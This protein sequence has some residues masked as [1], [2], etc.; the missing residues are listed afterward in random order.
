MF[1]DPR[2]YQI[3]FLATFLGLGIFTR[4]WSIDPILIATLVITCCLTQLGAMTIW[5]R[6]ENPYP[7]IKSAVITSLGLSLLLRA[8]R[9]STMILAGSLAIASKFIFTSN[10]K[11]W[12]N[13]A[14]FGIIIALLLAPDAWVSPG[15]WGSDWW[16]LVLFLGTGGI[17]LKRVGRWDTSGAF[18]VAYAGLEAARNWWLGST[19][20][21]YTHKL[22]S[23]SLLLFTLFMITDPRSIPNA[24]S[25]RIIWS[26]GIAGLAFILR[27]YFYINEGI[28]VALFALSPITILLDRGK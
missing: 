15:Q 4:D 18:L 22:M 2:D 7:S 26:I 14:N 23:G 1:V 28:F 11:H 16:Y 24:R 12:F 5:H 25:T 20:D 10:G 17:V 3:V 8:D 6:D 19:W 21:I 27:N 9:P 13:P